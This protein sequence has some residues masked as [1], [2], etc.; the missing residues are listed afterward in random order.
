MHNSTSVA[1]VV[2]TPFD[3]TSK[4]KCQ[5]MALPVK[6]VQPA[7]KEE[8]EMNRVFAIGTAFSL[9]LASHSALADDIVGTWNVITK[10]TFSTCKGVRVGKTTAVR[11]LINRTKR[12]LT[13]DVTGPTSYK[14]LTGKLSG[15]AVSFG[16]THVV[17]L[18]ARGNL[19][20][21]LALAIVSTT[22]VAAKHESGKLVGQKVTSTAMDVPRA[23][24]G[25][26]RE[27]SACTV[28]ESFEAKK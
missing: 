1:K 7:K 25:F 23:R 4:T 15:S 11:Y 8:R 24:S 16:G 22:G 9:L 21:G 12:K 5:T 28:I 14:K 3:L 10:V 13:V 18:P 2:N 19:F 20:T 27:V 17:R 26:H 6:M